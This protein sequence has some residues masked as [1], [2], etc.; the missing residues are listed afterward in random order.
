MVRGAMDVFMAAAHYGFLNVQNAALFFL[1]LSVLL[2]AVRPRP[3]P[4]ILMAIWFALTAGHL[5]SL[6]RPIPYPVRGN[7]FVDFGLG[8]QTLRDTFVWGLP[9]PFH[10]EYGA[11]MALMVASTLLAIFVA[12]FL[13]RKNVAAI[14]CIAGTIIVM[15]M[16]VYFDRYSIDTM[17]PLA[18]AIPIALKD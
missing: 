5:L 13:L 14:Y 11:R 1:P 18:I 6:H 12:A 4:A 15:F 9:Y 10:L 8:P 16:R 7:I 3:L 2:F 17:W